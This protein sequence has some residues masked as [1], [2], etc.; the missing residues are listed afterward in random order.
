[1]SASIWNMEFGISRNFI[2]KTLNL[3]C[4]C[5]IFLLILYIKTYTGNRFSLVWLPTCDL[6]TCNHP[7]IWGVT[8][9]QQLTAHE[10]A[11]QNFLF[12]WFPWNSLYH[13]VV[14]AILGYRYRHNAWNLAYI[15]YLFPK[16]SYPGIIL[17]Y[18]W[19]GFLF[20]VMTLQQ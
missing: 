4:W 9:T 7:V 5:H 8:V 2:L 16:F 19:K 11:L 12:L 20:F 14:S 17:T 15:Y 10:F 3:P 13:S 18:F 6:W 1:M